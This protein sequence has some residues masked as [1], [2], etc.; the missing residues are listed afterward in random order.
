MGADTWRMGRSS[1][2]QGDEMIQRALGSLVWYAQKH[3]FKACSLNY[4][5]KFCL[6]KDQE[7][8][9]AKSRRTRDR[10]GVSQAFSKCKQWRKV[11]TR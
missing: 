11:G 2:S 10:I 9:G 3:K 5:G 6:R 8:V 1:L 7:E 4:I